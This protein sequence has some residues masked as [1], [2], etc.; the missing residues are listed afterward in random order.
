MAGELSLITLLG[1]GTTADCIHEANWLRS[2]CIHH[3]RKHSQRYVD[4]IKG[5]Q[6]EQ[7][8]EKYLAQAIKQSHYID[9]MLTALLQPLPLALSTGEFS[10]GP[11][12]LLGVALG[13]GGTPS[14]RVTTRL[15]FL[16]LCRCMG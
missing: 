6:N 4:F 7:G 16:I 12:G 9:G 8:L 13:C 5:E 15:E 2:Q 10:F 14:F 1:R 3:I 11:A